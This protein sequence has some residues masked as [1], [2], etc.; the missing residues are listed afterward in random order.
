MSRRCASAA[1]FSPGVFQAFETFF[2]RSGSVRFTKIGPAR[3]NRADTLAERSNERGTCGHVLGPA[4]HAAR[5]NLSAG[6]VASRCGKGQPEAS[7]RASSR[8]APRCFHASVSRDRMRVV[9]CK[10]CEH[11]A[12]VGTGLSSHCVLA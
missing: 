5:E 1:W 7:S 6:M 10:S 2:G 9:A 8:S 3:I 4:L 12:G 11:A